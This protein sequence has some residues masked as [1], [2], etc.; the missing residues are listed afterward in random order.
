MGY[1][2][3]LDENGNII[4]ATERWNIGNGVR[5]IKSGCRTQD[6][7]DKDFE[8]HV[9]KCLRSIFEHEYANDLIEALNEKMIERYF[10]KVYKPK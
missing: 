7:G 8:S 9:T 2:I 4:S 3:D 5:R 10:V 1:E 6:Q